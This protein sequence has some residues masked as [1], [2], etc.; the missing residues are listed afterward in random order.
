RAC[1]TVGPDLAV[2]GPARP[3]QRTSGRVTSHSV[4]TA[5]AFSAATVEYIT[6]G[7]NFTPSGMIST[8]SRRHAAT[9]LPPAT[10]TAGRITASRGAGGGRCSS[11]Y[12][13]YASSG[14]SAGTPISPNAIAIPIT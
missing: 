4:H 9:T 8:G 3:L 7:A 14:A 2:V 5:T 11:E 1:A 13:T 6:S 12:S 10:S